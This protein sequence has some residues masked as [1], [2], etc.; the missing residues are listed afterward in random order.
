MVGIKRG[1]EACSQASDYRDN[2]IR[3]RLYSRRRPNGVYSIIGVDP[4]A[5]KTQI[6]LAL[7]REVKEALKNSRKNGTKQARGAS[8]RRLK[9]LKACRQFLA[10]EASCSTGR[11]KRHRARQKKAGKQICVAKDTMRRRYRGKVSPNWFGRTTVKCGSSID[12]KPSKEAGE[13]QMISGANL[14]NTITAAHVIIKRTRALRS[15]DK[16]LGPYA[17][18]PKEVL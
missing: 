18:L 5:P 6:T 12:D 13:V 15:R 9:E 3:R 10:Q 1:T 7:N 17:A 11:V 4:G 2:T 14:N 16:R 8:T